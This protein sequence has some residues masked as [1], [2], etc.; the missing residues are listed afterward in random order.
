MLKPLVFSLHALGRSASPALLWAPIRY[1]KCSKVSLEFSVLQTKQ[2]QLSQPVLIWEVLQPSD[3]LHSPSLNQA[4][5]VILKLGYFKWFKNNPVEYFL[6]WKPQSW[7]KYVHIKKY[8]KICFDKWGRIH[9]IGFLKTV[10]KEENSKTNCHLTIHWFD[11]FFCQ[12]DSKFLLFPSVKL[13]TS[14]AKELDFL[15]LWKWK[16]QLNLTAF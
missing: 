6:C 13:N 8:M 3:H 15:H 2:Y 1:W 9:Q 12:V 7:A 10:V 5:W 11:H 4:E 14:H 16:A